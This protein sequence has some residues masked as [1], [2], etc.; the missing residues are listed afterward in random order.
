MELHGIV[1]F[2]DVNIYFLVNK[3]KSTAVVI[4]CGT[5]SRIVFDKANE[6]GVTIKALLLTHAHFDHAG[7]GAQMQR[8]GVKVYVSKDDADKLQNDQNLA[9]HFGVDFDKFTPD[10]TFT[11]GEVLLLEGFEIKVLATP[12]HTDGSAT[13]M[14]GDMLF[15]GD[16]LFNGSVGR[17]DFPTGSTS[18]LSESV[19]RLYKLEGDYKVYPGHGDF[20]TLSRERKYNSFYRL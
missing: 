1:G 13:F 12:G 2:L 19:M 7:C 14:V 18:R 9:Y 10:Y 15:T 11:D 8:Q 3:E 6:L 16:T 5:D 17:T 4:D 20:S